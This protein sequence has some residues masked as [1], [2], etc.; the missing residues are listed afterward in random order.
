MSLN[1]EYRKIPLI[2]ISECI[3]INDEKPT[4]GRKLYHEKQQMED[5]F[6]FQA[7]H[8]EFLQHDQKELEILTLEI[9]SLTRSYNHLD[10]EGTYKNFP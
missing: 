9:T 1:R 7:N 5:D 6:E 4:V 8:K 2:E 10:R 3:N